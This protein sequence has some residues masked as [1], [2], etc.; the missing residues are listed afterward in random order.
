MQEKKDN[1]M[2]PV[3]FFTTNYLLAMIIHDHKK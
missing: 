1:D 2:K 3:S